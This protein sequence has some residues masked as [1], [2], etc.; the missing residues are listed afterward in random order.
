MSVFYR[1]AA[2]ALFTIDPE[3]AHALSLMALRMGLPLHRSLPPDPR[4]RTTVAGIDFPNPLGMAPGYDKDADVPDA[5]LHLGFGFV[6]V[7]T[8]A[9]L[10]QPGNPRPRV[11]RLRQDLGVINRLGFNT[12]GHEV[13][14]A[15]L[16][17]RRDKG[18]IVGVNIGANKLSAD[19]IGDYEAGVRRFAELASYITANISSPN[20]VGLR[21]L[22]SRASLAEL[23][24]RLLAARAASRAPAVPIFLKIAPDLHEDD[25]AD[26]AGECLDKKIDGIIVSNTTLSRLGAT[27]RLASE[28]GGLSGRPLFER[29]TIMLARLRRLVGPAM[30]LIG[31]GG[32][33]SAETAVEKIAA[34][35]DLVQLYTGMIYQ[36]P[37]IAADIVQGLSAFLDREKLGSLR[38]I[39]DS[40]TNEWANRVI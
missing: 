8:I 34:G 7:G 37:G 12:K 10:A 36:G 6:E 3:R 15:H 40:R 1:A 28:A 9:P 4:L 19:R 21:D 35:A 13:A 5:L 32:I 14:H 23:L 25:L 22:Q 30:P 20:T 11:F 38:E 2:P 33:D 16:S 18:G 24:E 26:I 29:S 39:R 31:V 27:D 17:A